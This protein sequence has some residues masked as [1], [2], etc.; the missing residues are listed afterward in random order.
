MKRRN[1]LLAFL[2]ACTGVSAQNFDEYFTDKT[3]RVD[4]LFTGNTSHQAICVDELSALPRWA[5][6]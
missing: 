5:G 6:R 4:Y 2:L 3:L 1:L